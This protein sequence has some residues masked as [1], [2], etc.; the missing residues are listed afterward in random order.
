MDINKVQAAYLD[1]LAAHQARVKQE[2]V[3]AMDDNAIVLAQTAVDQAKQKLA[4]AF[5]QD[6][7]ARDDLNP[8][9]VNE[10]HALAALE[11]ALNAPATGTT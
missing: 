2:G 11:A 4:D 7:S 1:W 3:V 5:S 6:Q 10:T 8:L 9:Q